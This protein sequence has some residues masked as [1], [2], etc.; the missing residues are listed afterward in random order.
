MLHRAIDTFT[1]MHEATKEAKEVF[2]PHYRLYSG[3]FI[4]VVYDHFLAN[5][6][7]EFTSSSLFD[8]SQRVYATLEE[9]ITWLPE[10][11]ATIFPYMKSHNWLFNYRTING[12]GK[13]FGGLV[14]RAAYLTESNTAIQLFEKHYQLLRQC[15]R[16][17]WKNVKLFARQEFET[18]PN[19]GSHLADSH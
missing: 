10:N 14:R 13:S 18:F 9:N 16:H 3:A 7:T 11:F 12:T 17:F 5:D 6:E 8:F 19:T 4:D 15:Y 2:R 1:D